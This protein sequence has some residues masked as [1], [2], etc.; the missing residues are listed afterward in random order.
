M[1][2]INAM[3]TL[4]R[5]PLSGVGAVM[6]ALL[7]SIFPAGMLGWFPALVLLNKT[8]LLPG[9]A[10]PVFLCVFLCTLASITFERGMRHYVKVG[11]NRY[12]RLGHRG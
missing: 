9:L 4:G 7:I 10:W 3:E 11:S 1:I 8:P 2:I 5:F 12:K 6:Q